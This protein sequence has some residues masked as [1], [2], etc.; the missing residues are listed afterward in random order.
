MMPEAS[1]YDVCRSIRAKDPAIPLIFISAKSEEIDKVLVEK[2]RQEGLAA[3]KRL[4]TPVKTK[5]KVVAS[6]ARK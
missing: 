1:G 3:F 6:K 2:I 5:K 4:L